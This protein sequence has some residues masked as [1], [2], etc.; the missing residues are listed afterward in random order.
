MHFHFCTFQR[1]QCE[2]EYSCKFCLM[3]TFIFVFTNL[4]HTG[5][6]SR[7]VFNFFNFQISRGGCHECGLRGQGSV[8]SMTFL[9]CVLI[10][11][12]FRTLHSWQTFN[13]ACS[14]RGQVDMSAR[15]STYSNPPIQIC[16][17]LLCCRP[18]ARLITAWRNLAWSSWIRSA[19]NMQNRVGLRRSS[20]SFRR[21]SFSFLFCFFV[22]LNRKLANRYGPGVCVRPPL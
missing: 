19:T 10:C 16:V 6:T 8:M 3:R 2:G 11:M 20:F 9:F 17:V 18:G 5:L 22:L 14:S 12:R 13:I 7:I 4:S 1:F 15:S 21:S